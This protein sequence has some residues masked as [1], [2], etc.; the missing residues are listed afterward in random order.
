MNTAPIANLRGDYAEMAPDWT[1]PQHADLYS[2]EE[3]TVWRVL[4]DRQ[5][6]LAERYACPE[7]LRGL[8]TLGIGETI[9][10]FAIVN[11]LLEP[12]TGWRIVGVPGL[13]PDAAFLRSSRQ[14]PLPGDG[15]DPHARRA[16][17]SGRA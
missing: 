11:A 17:L 2:D 1:V 12:L 6:T 8:E 9:P 14:S 3:H 15:L 13:I 7:F 4:R 10:D 5:S 16:G